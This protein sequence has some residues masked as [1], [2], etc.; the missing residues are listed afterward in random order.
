MPS[1][2]R[3]SGA[4]KDMT[5]DEI[6]EAIGRARSLGADGGQYVYAVLSTSGKIKEIGVEA[7]GTSRDDY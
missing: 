7:P 6:E 2:I 3:F 4:E 1:Q 5:L